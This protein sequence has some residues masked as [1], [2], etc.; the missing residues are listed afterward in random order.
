MNEGG[1]L[2]LL[3]LPLPLSL[4]LLFIHISFGEHTI[5]CTF[6]VRPGNGRGR[7]ATYEYNCPLPRS[8]G[9]RKSE[10]FVVLLG[11]LVGQLV[12]QPVLLFSVFIIIEN[13]E[14]QVLPPKNTLHPEVA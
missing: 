5:P 8:L 12:N 10:L 13:R 2:M 11:M 1:K 4:S 6:S 14:T 3:P 9:A 7:L